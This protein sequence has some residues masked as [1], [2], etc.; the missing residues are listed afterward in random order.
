MS[1]ITHTISFD[2]NGAPPAIL[3]R[4]HLGLMQ[5]VAFVASASALTVLGAITAGSAFT[6]LPALAPTGGTLVGQPATAIALSLKAVTATVNAPGLG[7]AINDTFVPAGGTLKPLGAASLLTAT[8]I[9]VQTAV[10]NAGGTGGTPGAVTITGTT[11]TGTKFQA[12][13]TINGSG[14]LTGPLVVTVAGDYTVGPTIAGDAVTGGSLTGATVA[15]QMGAKTLAITT[16]GQ[17]VL[18][19]ASANTPTDGTG[20]GTGVTLTLSYGLGEATITNSGNYSG[21]PSFTV[22]PTDGN[23]TGASIAAGTL[24]GNGNP[25]YVGQTIMLPATFNLVAQASVDCRVSTV[26]KSNLGW[27][28]ALTPPTTGSTLAAGFVDATILG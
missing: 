14:V 25:I 17:Y 22:T 3:D 5:S 12:T 27:S 21:A 4:L 1:L 2:P 11:G 10:V 26:A 23:G 8:H 13:G 9:Q 15:L 28:V 19:P 6:S 7:V 24:G 16:A 18:A 20:T